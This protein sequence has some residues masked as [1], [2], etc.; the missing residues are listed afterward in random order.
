[1]VRIAI[2]TENLRLPT[3]FHKNA[4]SIQPKRKLYTK[5][6]N[7]QIKNKEITYVYLILSDSLSNLIGILDR[8]HFDEISKLNQKKHIKYA[9]KE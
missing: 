6:K 5:Q 7:I 9:K 3:N 2:V 1:M 8:S 4:L